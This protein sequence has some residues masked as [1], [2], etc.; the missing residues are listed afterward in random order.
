V[1][2]SRVVDPEAFPC[3][4]IGNDGRRRNAQSRRSICG[5]VLVVPAR[6]VQRTGRRSVASSGACIDGPGM[7]SGVRARITKTIGHAD[8]GRCWRRRSPP[9][10]RS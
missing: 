2:D 7:A 5:R 10:T 6:R 4:D 3:V 1:G 9:R 8:A